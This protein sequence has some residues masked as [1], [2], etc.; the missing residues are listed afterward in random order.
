MI[1]S[2]RRTNDRMGKYVAQKVIQDMTNAGI[3]PVGATIGIYG[4]TFKPNCPDIRN[5]KVIDIINELKK[6]NCNIIVTDPWAN[7]VEVKQ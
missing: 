6:Y 3:N 4:I 1:L 2:G 7:K 5:T